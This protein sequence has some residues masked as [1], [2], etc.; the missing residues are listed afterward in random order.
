[1]RASIPPN[2]MGTYTAHWAEYKKDG[3]RGLCYLGLLVIIGLPA[4]ALVAYGVSQV[5]GEYPFYLHL[6]LLAVWLFAFVRLAIRYSRVTC[7]RC[8]TKYSRG[9]GL[10]NCP[11]CG[12]RMLQDEP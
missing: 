2:L 5:T 10:C 1:M 6:G 7:P 11:R 12:L 8:A 4:T 9:K 3:L